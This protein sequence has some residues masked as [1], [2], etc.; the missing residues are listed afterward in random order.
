M[1]EI[2]PDCKGRGVILK[3]NGQAIRCHCVVKRDLT[4]Y[5]TERYLPY[6]RF[7]LDATQLKDSQHVKGD[8]PLYN[9]FIKSFLIEYF[10]IN[11]NPLCWAS[12]SGNDLIDLYVTTNGQTQYYHHDV[13]FIDISVTHRNSSMADIIEYLTYHRSSHNCYA[14]FIYTGNLDNITISKKLSPQFAEMLLELPTI[15]LNKLDI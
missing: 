7:P 5:I 15:D 3:D 9:S 2:C 8:L 14:T 6:N 1:I 11:A 4:A 13:L 10:F 12:I